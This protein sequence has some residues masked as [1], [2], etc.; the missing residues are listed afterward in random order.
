MNSND[1][2][3]CTNENGLMT[4]E[5]FKINIPN[6]DDNTIYKNLV[7][8]NWAFFRPPA[9]EFQQHTH[10][11]VFDNNLYDN[12]LYEQLL[13]LATIKN[14]QTIHNATPKKRKQSDHATTHVTK[15]NTSKKNK[16]EK[17][18]KK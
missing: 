8:P 18:S 5:G 14:D 13:T 11:Q 15:K 7:A 2:V 16:R 10:K 1:F 9:P 6:Q 4:C 12:D 17:H 3:I